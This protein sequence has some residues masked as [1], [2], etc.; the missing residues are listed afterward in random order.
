MLKSI[1]RLKL[2]NRLSYN[3]K[4]LLKINEESRIALVRFIEMGKYGTFIVGIDG[5]TLTNGIWFDNLEDAEKSYSNRVS[6][7]G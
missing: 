5:L 7:R 3:G 4:E 2:E 1:Y 6:K